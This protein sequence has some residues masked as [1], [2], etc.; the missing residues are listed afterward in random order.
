MMA[1]TSLRLTIG[2]LCLFFTLTDVSAVHKIKSIN[3][4]KKINFENSVPK[5]SIILLYWFANTID[6]D[7]NDVI[8][9]TF[10]PNT[11][12]YG[13]HHYGNY[14]RILNP[15]PLGNSRYRYYTVGNLNPNLNHN[16]YMQLPSYVVNPQR[17][18]DGRNRDRIIFRVREQTVGNAEWQQIDEVYITQHY[19]THENQ[20]TRYDP[21]RTYMIT[22]NLLRQLR[23]FSV[24]RNTL[25]ELRDDFGSSIDDFQLRQIQIKWGD[26]ACLGL[27]LFIVIH[28]KYSSDQPDK[29]PQH[30]VRRNTQRDLVIDMPDDTPLFF[31]GLCLEV[32][33]EVTLQ[34]TTGPNG[35]AQI[36][37]ENIPAYCLNEGAKV[38][39]FKDNNDQETSNIYQ[40][41]GNRAKGTFDTSV[42]LNEGLQARLHKLKI[43]CCCFTAVGE[44]IFRGTEFHNPKAVKLNDYDAFIQLFVKN[45]KACARL[46]VSRSFSNWKSEFTESWVGLYTS[47]Y[48]NSRE[49]EWMEWQWATKFKSCN[50]LDNITHKVYEYCS[51]MAIASG[52]QA[53]F[54]LRDYN[55]IA[56]TPKWN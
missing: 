21:E 45:G 22:T 17:E 44:E 54:F 33:K 41:I 23:E 5:H 26:L 48:K 24:E 12:D 40:S 11:G 31:Q 35:N 38:V 15:L 47:E 18:Y 8:R 25:S 37:W 55:L 10:E 43:W 19:E 13:S 36:K 16:S 7:N 6:I 28:K 30:V 52:V 27:L 14:E 50:E 4:L 46:Y 32:G 39:L 29:R 2:C 3:G 34:V 42:K 1:K 51:G 56:N 9:L 53:R 49:Y 20:G